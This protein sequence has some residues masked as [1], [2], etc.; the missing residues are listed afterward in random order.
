M[1]VNLVKEGNTLRPVDYN[2]L[3]FDGW[4]TKGMPTV[5]SKWEKVHS[6]LLVCDVLGQ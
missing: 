3:P 2:T 4:N 6:P 1:H 5:S